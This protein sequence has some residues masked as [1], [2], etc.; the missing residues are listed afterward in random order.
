[1]KAKVYVQLKPAIPDGEGQRICAALHHLGYDNVEQVRMGKYIEL[2]IRPNERPASDEVQEMC[3]RLLANPVT[4][5][6]VFEI[7]ETA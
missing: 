7:I 6:Y 1:M 4:E 5:G 3:D 2:E